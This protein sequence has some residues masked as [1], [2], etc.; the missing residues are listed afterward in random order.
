[1]DVDWWIKHRDPKRCFSGRLF[2]PGTPC[3]W[4]SVSVNLPLVSVFHISLVF[5]T[6]GKEPLH[7]D[8]DGF[9]TAW[10]KLRTVQDL[11]NPWVS[12]FETSFETSFVCVC[13]DVHTCMHECGTQIWRKRGWSFKSHQRGQVIK[14]FYSADLPVKH[15]AGC[16]KPVGHLRKLK[17]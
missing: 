14:S 12:F 8:A 4:A 16:S 7:Q 10:I 6:R 11:T 15:L 1:M 17:L 5:N 2:K 9:W 3:L 13:V